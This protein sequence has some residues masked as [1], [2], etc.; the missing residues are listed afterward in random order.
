[1]KVRKIIAAVSAVSAI[2]LV[3]G[4]SGNSQQDSEKNSEI[5]KAEQ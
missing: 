3:A 4:C 2:L 1:M 5:I